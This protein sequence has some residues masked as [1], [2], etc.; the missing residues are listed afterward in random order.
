MLL[1]SQ[2]ITS[3]LFKNIANDFIIPAIFV[4]WSKVENTLE[5]KVTNSND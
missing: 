2:T 4:I 5:N 1:M 3:K